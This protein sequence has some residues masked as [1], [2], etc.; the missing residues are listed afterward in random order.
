[1]RRLICWSQFA[2]GATLIKSLVVQRSSFSLERLF[3]QSLLVRRLQTFP[4]L[5]QKIRFLQLSLSL[6]SYYLHTHSS[7]LFLRFLIHNADLVRIGFL[8]LTIIL[9]SIYRDRVLIHL[10]LSHFRKYNIRTPAQRHIPSSSVSSLIAPPVTAA[11]FPLSFSRV[12]Y[13]SA[14][15][16][17]SPGTL[18]AFLPELQTNESQGPEP[19]PSGTMSPSNRRSE[20]TFQISVI[21][22]VAVY[23]FCQLRGT[24]WNGMNLSAVRQS[25]IRAYKLKTRFRATLQ[26]MSY[27]IGSKVLN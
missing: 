18:P 15:N 7:S 19:V 4:A 8:I 24:C 27:F 21:P 14:S 1:M 11:N 23:M 2:N 16:H 5:K 20:I 12:S 9:V 13:T 17:V 3:K 25:S 6:F 10:F 26:V 22:L